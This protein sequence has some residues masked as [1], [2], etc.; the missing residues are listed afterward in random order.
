MV[1]THKDDLDSLG[2]NELVDVGVDCILGDEDDD[3]F[4]LA[5]DNRGLLGPTMWR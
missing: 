1:D 2:M 4:A 3:D 5:E